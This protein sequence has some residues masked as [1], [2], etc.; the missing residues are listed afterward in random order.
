MTNM[1]MARGYSANGDYKTAMT[2]LKKAQVQAPD[3]LNKANIEKL[4]PILE[5]GKT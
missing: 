2:Y 3:A 5:R 4:V 1:G